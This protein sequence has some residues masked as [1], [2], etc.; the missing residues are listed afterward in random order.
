[1]IRHAQ[2]GPRHNYD[3][4]SELGHRQAAL[5]G[6]YLAGEEVQ[7]TAIYTGGLRRQQQTA[8]IV[9]ECFKGAGRHAPEIQIDERWNE[10]SLAAVYRGISGRLT[11]ER[12]EFARDY[13]EM[14]AALRVDP[15]TTRGATG[16]CD[17]AVM[18][19]WME[20]RYPEYEGEAWPAFQGRVQACLADLAS[21]TAGHAVAVFTSATPIA[22][23]MGLA[24]GLSDE[25]VLNLTGTIYN[26]SLTTM[27]LRR[28]ELTPFTF[29]CTP[30]LAEQLA[31]R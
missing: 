28:G 15:H 5:L 8:A 19:A 21:H 16:R 18:Q 14:K 29:N 4:L 17:R 7:L 11:A 24:L 13:E 10:F 31:S 6:R 22:I 27:R 20:N 2:A 12:E 1:L 26:S 9:G 3:A 30:H 25:K 23:W